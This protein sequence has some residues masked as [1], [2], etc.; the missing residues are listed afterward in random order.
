MPG[1][2]PDSKGDPRYFAEWREGLLSSAKFLMDSIEVCGLIGSEN[3]RRQDAKL[4]NQERFD[5]KKNKQN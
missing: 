5:D 3:S 4:S 2:L 1:M